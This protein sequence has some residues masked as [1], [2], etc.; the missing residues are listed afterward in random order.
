MK[1]FLKYTFIFALPILIFLG[2]V[3]F[4]VR[5]I[6]NDYQHK[7][8]WMQKNA[9]DVELLVLG[10]S[11]AYFGID[12]QYFECKAFSIANVSQDLEYDYKILEKYIN[13]CNRLKYVI[14]TIDYPSFIS[15]LDEGAEAWRLPYYTIYMGIPVQ[16]AKY[17]LEVLEFERA[18]GKIGSF[19]RDKMPPQ[20]SALG[21]GLSY[22]TA[23]KSEDWYK[24]E[25]AV[26]RHTGTNP[27]IIRENDYY[28][29][30]IVA[31][32]TERNVKV[33]MI[34]PPAYYTYYQDVDKGQLNMMTDK[35]NQVLSRY[36]QT[37]YY[38]FFTDSTFKADDFFDSDHLSS[39]V[40]AKHFTQL[41][42]RIIF[43]SK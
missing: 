33:I 3:E 34:T 6:P 8:E 23:N 7:T 1:R 25:A 32:C 43:S 35:I 17:Q 11:H 14:L 38:N 41:L 36:N 4:A 31:C 27:E 16:K 42:N 29:N 28:L 12:P 26:K 40:G 18:K 15:K 2:V 20:W 37:C 22:K 30:K 19:Y 9:S 39:D 24:A 21:H 5:R 13:K 10:N